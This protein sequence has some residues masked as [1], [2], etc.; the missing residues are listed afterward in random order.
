MPSIARSVSAFAG[1]KV[2]VPDGVTSPQTDPL[3]NGTVL[4]LGLRQLLLGLESLVA[5]FVDTR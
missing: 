5:L 1:V 3:R 4:L 2:V